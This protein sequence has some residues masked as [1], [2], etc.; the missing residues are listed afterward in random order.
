MYCLITQVNQSFLGS[1]CMILAMVLSLVMS[2]CCSLFLFCFFSFFLHHFLYLFILSY[3]GQSFKVHW[4]WQR[5]R[6]AGGSGAA[7]RGQRRHWVLSWWGFRHWG[8]QI[9]ETIVSYRNL[10][11]ILIDLKKCS[12][13]IYRTCYYASI[14]TVYY[15]YF[16]EQSM[17]CP[18]NSKTFSAVNLVVDII[19]Y[20]LSSY[21]RNKYK[22]IIYK[23]TYCMAKG[24][25]TP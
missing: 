25:W 13:I 1:R 6:A 20:N 24:L 14:I 19:V 8:V 5:C 3:S 16:P 12:N 15:Y 2:L 9:S 18:A 10:C 4:I 21:F 23:I 22:Y 17:Y 7:G 11:L